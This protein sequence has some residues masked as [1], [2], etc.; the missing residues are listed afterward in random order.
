MALQ[1]ISYVNIIFLV[2]VDLQALT[3]S[4]SVSHQ[5]KAA[6]FADDPLSEPDGADMRIVP[7]SALRS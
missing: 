5:N 3:A 1:S 2:R 7:S 6:D 4:L